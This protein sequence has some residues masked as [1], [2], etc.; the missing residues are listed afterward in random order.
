MN[1]TKL[2]RVIFWG[3][4]IFI[5]ASMSIL[6]MSILQ[7]RYLICK[8][9]TWDHP[10]G[11]VVRCLKVGSDVRGGRVEPEA[12][13]TEYEWPTLTPTEWEPIPYA[14]RTPTER[15]YPVET[16]TPGEYP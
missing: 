6:I 2:E 8:V 13:A 7:N 3:L 10:E 1:L 14:T 15:P 12:T 5:V 11:R 4:W 9:Y 16:V